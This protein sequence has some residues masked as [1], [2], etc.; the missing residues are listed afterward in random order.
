MVEQQTPVKKNHRAADFAWAALI[1]AAVGLFLAWRA[2]NLEQTSTFGALFLV[3][4]AVLL[5]VAL[6]TRQRHKS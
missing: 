3:V 6:V 2:S 4:A 1:A 5:V